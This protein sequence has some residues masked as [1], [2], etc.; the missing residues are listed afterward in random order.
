V[1]S[2]VADTST[3]V[4]SAT[5]QQQKQNP[6]KNTNT[7]QKKIN[8]SLELAAGMD[9]LLAAAEVIPVCYYIIVKLQRS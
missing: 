1:H 6:P 9:R 8:Q 2:P 7:Q 4:G 3:L 5:Q